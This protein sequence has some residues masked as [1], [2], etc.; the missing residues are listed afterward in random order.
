MTIRT[1]LFVITGVLS[2]IALVL[3]GM[4]AKAALDERS[5]LQAATQINAISDQY[6]AAAAAWAVERGTAN[7]VINN[8]A[9]ATDAQRQVIATQRQLGDAA[10]AEAGRLLGMLDSAPEPARR[11]HQQSETRRTELAAM[12]ARVDQARSAEPALI[13]GWFVAA[14]QLV[15]GTQNARMA[16]E[17]A[18]PRSLPSGVRGLFE[19]KGLLAVMSEAAGRERGG[20]AG[21]IAGGK[22]LSGSQYLVQG[23]NRGQ[24]EISWAALQALTGGLDA[25]IGNAVEGLGR[26]YFDEFEKVRAS[27]YYASLNGLPYPLSATEWFAS[28]TRAIN[29]I[30][31]AQKLATEVAGRLIARENEAARLQLLLATLIASAVAGVALLSM[32]LIR[33]QVVRPILALSKSMREIAAGQLDFDISGVHRRDEIGE[34]AS[35]VKIFR[36]TAIEK[37]H[38]ARVH[39]QAQGEAQ[40]ERVAALQEMAENVE[41]ET[42][43]A[44]GEVHEGTEQM[45]GNAVRMNE[46]AVVLQRNSTSVAA[47]AEEALSNSE[48]MA[49]AS[50]ELSKSITEIASQVSAS[51][52]LTVEAV[53]ASS[54]A[55]HII[56]MLSGAA[57]K[58]GAVT[59]I[60]SEIAS[61]T[62]LLALNATIEA[63]RAGETGRGFAVVAA[64]V[65]SLAG[66]TAKATSEIAQQ[67]A[68][69]QRATE[70]SVISIN[71]IG[72]VIRSVESVSSVISVA[73]EEQSAVTVEIAR[74][75][76]QTSLAAR[77]VAAQIVVVSSEATETGR[78]AAEMQEGASVIARQ[79]DGLRTSLV[80]VIRTS[81]DEVNRRIFA[82]KEVNRPGRLELRGTAHSVLVHEISEGGAKIS[83]L[84]MEIGEDEPITLM[85]DDLA[86]RLSGFASRAD[87]GGIML[88]FVLAPT[89]L[90]AVREFVTGSRA[91]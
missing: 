90:A 83:G 63:A 8:P 69:I 32:W 15:A 80:R 84:A 17:R 40:R 43:S 70:E 39:L 87:G 30:V 50:R 74:S 62:N 6:L 45:A 68:E 23:G 57:S 54:K 12:R 4:Y 67:I 10:F 36:E 86:A 44:V 48:T 64:E 11:S 9:A 13:S 7:T 16:T 77:E 85:V 41:R 5:G 22:P 19:L 79:V 71:A 53:A 65:K 55:Q 29:E 66:Q 34:M 35:A 21:A 89:A 3:V 82:R 28:A 26:R 37:Q 25:E 20:V 2:V 49:A 52:A 46:S 33:H 38:L 72:E 60:I 81:T 42:T 58:V 47:A 75:V 18:L 59:D 31:T 91:A 88:R 78:R 24:I 1:K 27:V 61:Q 73:V 56:A 51:R 14:S 76:E